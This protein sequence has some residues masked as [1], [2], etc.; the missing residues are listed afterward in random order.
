MAG[1]VITSSALPDTD[2]LGTPQPRYTS[3]LGALTVL[4]FAFGFITCLNDILIPFLKAIFG[5]TYAQ[6][7]LINGCFFGA[8]FVM[9]I[10]AGTLVKRVGYKR[11]MLLGFLIAAVGCFLFY[12]AAASRSLSLPV[13]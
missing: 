11:G 9:G 6:A 1:T 2:D 12:P 13:R 10:P 8:Y 3:A 7:N 4:F 5:L